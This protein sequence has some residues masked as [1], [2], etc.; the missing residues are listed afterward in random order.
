MSVPW[1]H[2]IIGLRISSSVSYFV[3]K[4]F[5]KVDEYTKNAISCN[6]KRFEQSILNAR[7]A[8]SEFTLTATH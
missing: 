8:T 7:F 5:E 2:S 6:P 1:Q 4:V 3:S